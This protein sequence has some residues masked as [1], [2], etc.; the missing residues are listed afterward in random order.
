MVNGLCVMHNSLA[1]GWDVVG[2]FME[3]IAVLRPVSKQLNII[4]IKLL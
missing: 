4:V 2:K 3:G 1:D